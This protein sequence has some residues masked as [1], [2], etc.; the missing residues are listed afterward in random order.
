MVLLSYVFSGK[1]SKSAK[2]VNALS[3]SWSFRSS[4]SHRDAHG[5][6]NA[7]SPGKHCRTLEKL[8][9]EEQKLYKQVK[10]NMLLQLV[11]HLSF[12]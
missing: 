4:H 7:T 1:S 5:A 6:S 3:W 2:V 11:L 9:A 10:V 12:R 8:F